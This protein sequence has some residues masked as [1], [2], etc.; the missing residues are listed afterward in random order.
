MFRSP[1]SRLRALAIPG[2]AVPAS[3]E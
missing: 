1:V 2:A 3:V